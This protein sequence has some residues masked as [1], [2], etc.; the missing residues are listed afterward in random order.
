MRSGVPNII[1]QTWETLDVPDKWKSCPLTVFEKHTI[2]E[3]TENKLDPISSLDD[4][5]KYVLLTNEDRRSFI[6]RHFPQYLDTFNKLRHKIQEADMIRYAWLHVNGGIY[7]DLDYEV[8]KPL[9]TLFS[10]DSPVYFIQSP[11]TDGYITNSFMAS[12]PGCEIWLE[13]LAEIDKRINQGK[14]WWAKGKHL[15]VMMTTG[16]GMLQK[17]IQKTKTPYMILP[18]NLINN[19]SVKDFK[20]MPSRDDLDSYLFPL[21]GCSWGGWDSML[22]NWVFQNWEILVIIIIVLL[23]LLTVFLVWY[24]KKNWKMTRKETITIRDENIATKDL[25]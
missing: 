13:A 7:M 17:V 9:N 23:I 5:Y 24:F 16:P 22:Y 10:Y 12:K 4:Q 25:T 14:E 19:L 3:I 2:E 18:K 15:E 20:C 21:E 11:N 6:A 1:V 8:L